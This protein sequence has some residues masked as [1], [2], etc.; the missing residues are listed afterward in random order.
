LRS[1]SLLLPILL[2]F[3]LGATACDPDGGLRRLQ[4]GRT[5]IVTGDFDTVEQLLQEVSLTTSVSAEIQFFD[6]YID[7]AHFETEVSSASTR[8]SQQVE[9]LLRADTTEGLDF[10]NTAFL[11]CGMRGV[12]D[13]VYNGVAEDNHLVLDATVINNVFAA[14][15]HGQRLY[16][17]DWTYDLLEAT[18][19]DKVEWLGSDTELDAAQR[20]RPGAVNARVVDQGLADF[21]EIGLGEQIEVIFNQGGWA[22]IESVGDDV[23]VLVEA[24]IEYDDPLTGEV[25][26]RTSPLV[27]AFDGG[28]GHVVFTSFHNEAQ[29]TD[30]ARDVLRYQ[31]NQLSQN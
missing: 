18:W 1:R 27:V 5:A 9:D 11:A 15:S 17:S 22:V 31:L 24:E 21:M 14:V 20:G 28:G 4:F 30:D 19:P 23:N 25:A 8:P 29:I 2:V 16:F 12:A 6:G 26:T 7:G 10:F 3:A 13:R